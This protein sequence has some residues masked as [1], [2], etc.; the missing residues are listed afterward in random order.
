MRPLAQMC[1]II[2]V[3]FEFIS[4]VST[5]AKGH[6]VLVAGISW[7]YGKTT[8]ARHQINCNKTVQNHSKRSDMV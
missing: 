4:F 5:R 7:L 3:K 6:V 1:K 8:L 2:V